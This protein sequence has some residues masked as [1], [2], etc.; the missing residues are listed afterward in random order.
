MAKG[1]IDFAIQ[2]SGRERFEVGLKNL[3]EAGAIF[4]MVQALQ[5]DRDLGQLLKGK[6]HHGEIKSC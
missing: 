5:Y 3:T 1:Q 2:R 6:P 4:E